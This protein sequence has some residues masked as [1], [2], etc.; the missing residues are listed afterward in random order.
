MQEIEADDWKGEYIQ[1][2]LKAKENE[3]HRDKM[4][5]IWNDMYKNMSEEQENELGVWLAQV[6]QTEMYG[7]QI[8]DKTRGIVDSIIASYDEMPKETQEAMKNAMT[9]M[10]TEMENK[11]PSLF[12]KASGIANGILSRLKKSFD[13]HSPSRKTRKIM[14]FAMQPMEEEM[15]EGKKKLFKQADEIGEGITEKLDKIEGKDVETSITAK[16]KKINTIYENGNSLID[17]DK[18][19]N[20][21][22]KALTN[23][24]FTL[25]EDGFAKIVK[26]ELYKVV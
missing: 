3:K 26:D 15:E 20:A 16:G 14:K 17:Y 5:S 12:A 9:P 13:I 19:A 1:M 10:L 21:I 11:E 23:C 6:A 2:D 24:K 8:D 18:M 22:T 7:G 4:K 25:D